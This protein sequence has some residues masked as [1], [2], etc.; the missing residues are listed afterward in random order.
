MR[1]WRGW[2]TSPH[3]AF[4]ASQMALQTFLIFDHPIWSSCRLCMF[5]DFRREREEKNPRAALSED[6]DDE[7]KRS[8]WGGWRGMDKAL[9]GGKGTKRWRKTGGLLK[10]GIGGIKTKIYCGIA[11]NSSKRIPILTTG[12]WDGCCVSQT[13]AD[14]KWWMNLSFS[15]TII[16]FCF[17]SRNI[18]ERG[19]KKTRC[20]QQNTATIEGEAKSQ[21]CFNKLY[22]R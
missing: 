2:R 18:L 13:S 5:E 16:S 22:S 7:R 1:S 11:G 19:V 20:K 17:F 21:P 12:C 4:K 6:G 9:R 10:R 3:L 8:G 14:L 15:F